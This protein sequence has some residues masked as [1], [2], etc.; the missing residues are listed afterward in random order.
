MC[1]L[2]ALTS[3]HI[4]FKRPSQGFRRGTYVPGLNFKNCYFTYWGGSHIAVKVSTHRLCVICRH[5]YSNVAVSRPCRLS[6]FTILGSF[7]NGIS[8]KCV[9]YDCK[10]KV[11]AFPRDK[12]KPDRII[13]T[14]NYFIVSIK[15]DLDVGNVECVV[16][17]F[18]I[19]VAVSW[20]VL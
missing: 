19:L 20:T 9:L 7:P 3:V 4:T 6:N 5:F 2:S 17:F 18:V 10:G 14:S 12:K 16:S 8:F 13:V 1:L 11:G 15:L